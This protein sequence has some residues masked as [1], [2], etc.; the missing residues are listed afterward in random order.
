MLV[1]FAPAYERF[2]NSILAPMNDLCSLVYFEK[3]MFHGDYLAEA[4]VPAERVGAF[5]DAMNKLKRKG[6][7]VHLDTSYDWLRT[8]PMRA[9]SYDVDTGC[10]DSDYLPIQP[11]GEAGYN[12]ATKAKFDK[13]D[14]LV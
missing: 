12:A 13:G 2:S 1:D 10:W 7:F 14:R 3:R 8:I 11:T 9:G 6:L 4:S 5:V